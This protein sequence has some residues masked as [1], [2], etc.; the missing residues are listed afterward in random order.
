MNDHGLKEFLKKAAGPAPRSSLEAEDI[1]QKIKNR[2][3]SIPAKAWASSV[4]AVVALAIYL[5]LETVS[6]EEV[7]MARFL[8]ETL[9]GNYIE[10][11][12]VS[13]DFLS[14]WE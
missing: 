9:N 12:A 13:D 3:R 4:G 7:E 6:K 1:F 2:P 10:E 8:N 14:I 11:E 5:N